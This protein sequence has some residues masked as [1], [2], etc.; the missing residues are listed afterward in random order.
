LTNISKL[1]ATVA[2]NSIY[3]TGTLINMGVWDSS[4]VTPAAGAV[5]AYVKH[6]FGGKINV[7]SNAA[8]IGAAGVNQAAI[9]S[10]YWYR[11]SGVP[12]ESCASV[13]TSMQNTAAGIY[14]ASAATTGGATPAGTNAAYKVPGAD[15]NTAN[16]SAACASADTV[17]ISLFILS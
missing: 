13:A 17:E 9:G 7:A 3:N 15:N 11:L 16:L 14:I 10:G 8:A 6:P 12:S 5:A 1:Y 4:S 2:S